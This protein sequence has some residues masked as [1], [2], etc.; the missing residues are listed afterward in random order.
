MSSRR[1]AAGTSS[2]AASG[3]RNTKDW[4]VAFNDR[5]GPEYYSTTN[6]EAF[7]LS[8]GRAEYDAY[9]KELERLGEEYF[10]RKRREGGVD[11]T[12]RESVARANQELSRTGEY[13]KLRQDL[14][15]EIVLRL[16]RAGRL[17]EVAAPTDGSRARSGRAVETNVDTVIGKWNE[18]GAGDRTEEAQKAAFV[19][20]LAE[21][22]PSGFK[23][24]AL[25]QAAKLLQ[26]KGRSTIKASGD[27]KKFGLYNLIMRTSGRAE[28]S[29]PEGIAVPAAR[30]VTTVSAPLLANIQLMKQE[31]A[32]LGI[33]NAGQLQ[34]LKRES[35]IELARKGGLKTSGLKA[36]LVNRIA[37]AVSF[38]E[39]PLASDTTRQ[40][41]SLIELA[42]TNPAEAL[43]RIKLI[44]ADALVNVPR[45]VMVRFARAVRLQGL[46]PTGQPSREAIITVLTGQ[47]T[48]TS[49][50]TS[51]REE[52]LRGGEDA[53]NTA[54]LQE[55]QSIA[56][57]LGLQVAGLSKARLC[58]QIRAQEGVRQ[59]RA[60]IT[61]L[62][63]VERIV[64][65]PAGQER[66]NAMNVFIRRHHLP[67]IFGDIDATPV[68]WLETYYLGRAALL[69]P[70]MGR[71]LAEDFIRTGRVP[72]DPLQR[73]SLAM[74]FADI[75]PRLQDTLDQEVMGQELNRLRRDFILPIQQGGAEAFRLM[76]AF[77]P[78]LLG[79][80]EFEAPRSP[81]AQSPRRAQSVGPV[82]GTSTA[83]VAGAWDFQAGSPVTDLR[84]AAT[85][86][87]SLD[88]NAGGERNA[89]DTNA[90]GFSGR[91]DVVI[92][93]A[94]DDLAAIQ[95]EFI[96]NAI[97]QGTRPGAYS[98]MNAQ[99][100]RILPAGNAQ[101][102]ADMQRRASQYEAANRLSAELRADLTQELS[103]RSAQGSTSPRRA[104]GAQALP[105][106]GGQAA[107][108]GLF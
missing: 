86:A 39:M 68:N 41:E 60:L 87:Y 106:Q 38:T 107:F 99:G 50:R 58:A 1:S 46:P 94:V 47:R 56:R 49:L 71:R 96:P 104:Q 44:S 102:A 37:D 59:A 15:Y 7:I 74:V 48:S 32:H 17:T 51:R 18:F 2:G 84:G 98:T 100:N 61:G 77:S 26:T 12:N 25:E 3:S 20:W 8:A 21:S 85:A 88:E 70:V 103:P 95:D 33:A 73:E 13:R 108:S 11:E 24:N 36:E 9:V 66:T 65:S 62:A 69:D 30:A 5:L 6:L 43:T 42:R 16:H 22:S 55:V 91:R 67:T 64:L 4:Y 101:R 83:A 10:L 34:A 105:P 76:R 92:P 40:V 93:G 75:A 57:D 23:I 82:A 97:G 54:T 89:R 29:A 28:V 27:A 80:E 45:D 14:R 79:V 31:L 81:R 63:D 90:G 53:C 52:I 78:R 19:S 72:V 35:L